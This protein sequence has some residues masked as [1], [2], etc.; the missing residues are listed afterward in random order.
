VLGL[1][2]LECFLAGLAVAG[3]GSA[4]FLFFAKRSLAKRR[5]WLS[6]SLPDVEDGRAPKEQTVMALHQRLQ[7]IEKR[8]SDIEEQMRRQVVA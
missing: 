5:Q 7:A 8:L 3:F 4:L 1:D 6:D 2:P